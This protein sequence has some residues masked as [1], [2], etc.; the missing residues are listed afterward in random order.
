MFFFTIASNTSKLLNAPNNHRK[1]LNDPSALYCIT[2]PLSLLSMLSSLPLLHTKKKLRTL[3]R[4]KIENVK[5]K[6]VQNAETYF[7]CFGKLFSKYISCEIFWKTC[8]R[9]HRTYSGRI[10]LRIR[11]S[12]LKYFSLVSEILIWK[13]WKTCSD[14]ISNLKITFMK[15]KMI[16]WKFRGERRNCESA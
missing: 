2:L 12:F 4:K 10:V 5:I 16:F 14:R 3:K 13:F 1:S 7:M 6:L 8:S 9:R 11:R 15:G